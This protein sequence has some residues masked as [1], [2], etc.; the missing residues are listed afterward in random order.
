[1]DRGFPGLQ[2]ALETK[3]IPVKEC[4]KAEWFS[5][6]ALQIAGGKKRLGKARGRKGKICPTVCRVPENSKED[7]KASLR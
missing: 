1:M 4:K 2:R 5:E 6:E 3:I 7:K